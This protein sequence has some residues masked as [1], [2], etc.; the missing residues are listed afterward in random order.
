TLRIPQT[1]AAK[2]M[3]TIT[4]RAENAIGNVEHPFQLNITTAPAIK[5]QLKDLETLRG[6]DAIFIVDVQGYPLPEL[7]WL[8]GEEQLI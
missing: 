2:H 6:L 3:G 4:C 5:T 8:H 1:D 7:T